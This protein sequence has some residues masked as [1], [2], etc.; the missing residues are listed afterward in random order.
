MTLRQAGVAALLTTLVLGAVSGVLFLAAFQLRLE[1]FAD[2]APLVNAGA[3]SAEFLRWA[4]I[5]DLFSYYLATALVAYVLWTVLRS[6]G[7]AIAD[8]ATAAA[9]GYVLIGG[10]AASALAFIGPAL[11]Q[12]H[13]TPG[14]DQAAVAVAF[15]VL[16][17]VVFRAIWQFLDAYLLAAWWL[18]VGLLLRAEQ[19]GFARLSLVLAAVAVVGTAFTV[20]DIEIARYGAL[21]LFF[22]LWTA[23]NIWLLVLLWRRRQPFAALG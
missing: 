14:T 19:P 13:A 3:T 7:G 2:P 18:G 8:L 10:A 11:M 23:W 4:A 17:D 12:A 20:L 5:A 21:G 6:R 1:W 9:F 15:G 16:S 22:A